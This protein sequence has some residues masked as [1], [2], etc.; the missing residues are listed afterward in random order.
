VARHAS[1]R[2]G[3]AS[4]LK[5]LVLV[6][7]LVCCGTAC[8]DA[9]STHLPRQKTSSQIILLPDNL[10]VGDTLD[11]HAVILTP[12]DTNYI[13]GYEFGPGLDVLNFDT[14]AGKGCQDVVT[15]GLEVPDL[16]HPTYLFPVCLTLVAQ[17]GAP[18][19]QRTVSM[20]VESNGTPVVAR[21]HFYVLPESP[22]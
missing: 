6:C 7:G 19:G 17:A 11:L 3:G 8:G 13:S 20:D 9:Y 2:P 12:T 21:G 22:E 18:L 1:R 15:E 4:R 5:G 10:R 16:F 14:G